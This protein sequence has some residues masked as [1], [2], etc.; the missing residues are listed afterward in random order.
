M[1]SLP[2]ISIIV[3]IFNE[4][5]YIAK[6]L[7]SIVQ[8]DYDKKRMEVLLVDGGST[9]KTVEIIKEYQKGYPFFRLFENPE[10]IV[11]VAMNLGIEN[12]KGDF[13]IRLDAHASYPKDY[14]LKLVSWSEKLDA[15][16]VGGIVVTKVKN[17]NR[18]SNA[19]RNV[20]SDRLGVGSAF[21]SGAKKIREV[22]TV[23]F[24]CYKKDLFD[25]IGLYNERLVRN[26]DIE[27]NKRLKRSGGKI[28]IVPEIQCT[29][30]ARESF[31][32]LA[33][34]SFENGKWNILTAYYTKTFSSLSFR[35]FV[36][37]LFLLSLILPLFCCGIVSLAILG[38]YLTVI[39][40]RSFQIRRDTTLLHQVAAFAVLHF[41]YAFGEAA[42]IMQLIKRLMM[43]NR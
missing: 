28:Y 33:K 8:S 25:R 31:R 18:I 22:D 15:D 14:F 30:F 1:E 36:P 4:E 40:L 41:N 26:Q 42:G 12:A 10:K 21:R 16:N 2:R 29:Y 43:G 11:P 9:D 32:E 17:K 38:S 34:N 37:L 3:P 23:P 5:K 39:A 27:L 20:L 13:V 6:C 35:H 19:I 24:G 7:E